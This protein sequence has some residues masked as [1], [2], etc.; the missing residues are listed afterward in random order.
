MRGKPREL[1]SIAGVLGTSDRVQEIIGEFG[2]AL[3]IKLLGFEPT[4]MNLDTNHGPDNIALHKQT[5]IWGIFESKG[6]RSRLAEGPSAASYGDQMG[7]KWIR[8]WIRRTILNNP[9]SPQAAQLNAAFDTGQP[10]LAAVTRLNINAKREQIKIGVQ[11]FVS[12]LG[13]GMNPWKGF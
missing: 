2:S 5:D 13:I 8:Y 9:G 3:L 4:R 11:V 1:G 7:P 10:M 6:G 12:P